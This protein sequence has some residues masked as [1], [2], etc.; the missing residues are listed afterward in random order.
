MVTYRHEM[1][2]RQAIQSVLM[3]RVDFDVEL[4][5]A[6]DASPDNTE[7]IVR[8]IVKAHPNGNWI[9]YARQTANKGMMYNFR[10]ALGRCRGKYIA[11]LD[12]DDYWLPTDKLQRQVAHLESN[13][14]THLCFAD[15]LFEGKLTQSIHASSVVFRNNLDYPRCFSEV[16][17]GDTFLYILSRFQGAHQK[18]DFIGHFRRRHSGSV[19]SSKPFIE[20]LEKAIS[21][22]LVMLKYISEQPESEIKRF[23]ERGTLVSY[24]KALLQLGL[25][26][27]SPKLLRQSFVTC[28]KS[29]S[30]V[31]AAWILLKTGIRFLLVKIQ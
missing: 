20:K 6:D 22:N 10:D 24:S 15:Y 16:W 2:I 11:L 26:K 12:G 8:E 17:N 19:W 13:S 3:Q 9:K 18:I 7:N 28:T 21:S 4:V 27:R 23:L 29:G 14:E 25:Q 30:P 1:F 31:W 5:V